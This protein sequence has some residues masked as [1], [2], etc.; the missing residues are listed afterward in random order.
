MI[1]PN[2]YTEETLYGAFIFYCNF[3]ND[4]PIPENLKLLCSEKPPGYN[5]YWSIQEKVEYLKKNGKRYS[6]ENLVELMTIIYRENYV[7]AFTEKNYSPTEILMQFLDTMNLTDSIIIEQPIRR[8]LGN[9][10]SE[11]EGEPKERANI[12]LNNYLIKSN[13]RMFSKIMEF[14]DNYGNM[15]K[16]EYDKVHDF[17]FGIGD[18]DLDTTEQ[19]DIYIIANFMKNMVFSISKTNPNIIINNS[20]FTTIPIHWALASNHISLIAKFIDSY[21]S[22]FNKF[23]QN[24][25][26]ARFLNEI[27]RKLSDLSLFSQ[28]LNSSLFD[29]MTI[30]KLNIYCV[31][32]CIYEYIVL[33]GDSELIQLDIQQKRKARSQQYRENQDDSLQLQTIRETGNEEEDDYEND[34][35]E[36]DIIAGDNEELKKNVCSL[37]L[38]FI[39]YEKHNKSIINQ[40]YSKIA[41]RVSKSKKDEKDSITSYLENMEVDERKIEDSLKQYKLE[42]WNAGQQKG[43]IKYDRELY[44][45]QF[46]AN[47][48]RL[49]EDLND[50]DFN[51]NEIYHSV[52]AQTALPSTN[53][54]ELEE[55]DEN[56]DPTIAYGRELPVDEYYD[57]YDNGDGDGD[58]NDGDDMDEYI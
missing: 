26:V 29:R 36:I 41:K 31:Y 47:E 40:S 14:V 7:Y 52:L 21:K 57:G 50:S 30:L 43:L 35:N 27:T 1:L 20:E 51:L 13:N 23:K 25:V 15:S 28:M 44:D 45:Q 24:P 46:E 5:K 3:D 58:Y 19:Q 34:L 9:Y 22:I 53:I 4:V 11:D 49:F 55:Y 48:I 12:Q 54:E 17:L 10:L 42:R 6:L 18:W 16:N 56:P 32:S 39:N 2:T 38:A 37:L 33:S 8:L